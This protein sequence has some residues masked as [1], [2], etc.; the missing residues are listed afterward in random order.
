MESLFRYVAP[1]SSCGY[2]P[3]QTWR[4]EYEQVLSLSAAEYMTRM[5]Q[6]WRR[7]GY[8]LFRP[9]CPAC[10]ACRSLR[11]PVDRFRPDRSQ[12]R[13]RAANENVVRLEIGTPAVTRAKLDLYDRYHAFQSENKNWPEH[14]GKDADDYARTFVNNPFATQEWCYYLDDRLI[15]VGYVDNLPAGLSAIYFIYEPTE[16]QRSL[17]TWNVLS[18]IERARML[19]VPHVYLGYYVAGCQSMQYKTRFAPNQLRGIDGQWRDFQK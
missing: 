8:L 9:R 1:P 5:S 18:I 14:D 17:G 11:V 4:L 19:G 12:R 2:L 15:A 3:D 10:N 16:R 7:F 13:A 6:G